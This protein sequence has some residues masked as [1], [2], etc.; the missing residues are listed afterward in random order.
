MNQQGRS[1][2]GRTEWKSGEMSGE[3]M[4]WNKVERAIKTVTD[5][6]TEQE[7]VGK[8]GWSVSHINRNIPNTWRWAR[9]DWLTSKC[10]VHKTSFHGLST[11]ESAKIAFWQ[12][13]G[14]H[15]G[16]EE[17]WVSLCS[18]ELPRELHPSLLPV[19]WVKVW[20]GG[21]FSSFLPNVSKF[22]IRR[23]N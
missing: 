14:C 19:K 17:D 23:S 18:G 20:Q 11:R 21:L 2:T 7:E 5:T 13:A 9:G 4:E 6:R 15:L 22:C 12:C 8:L 16:H 1:K 10:L 3:F